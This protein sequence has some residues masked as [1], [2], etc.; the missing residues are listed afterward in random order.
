MPD[1]ECPLCDDESTFQVDTSISPHEY[2]CSACGSY[3]FDQMA[4]TDLKHLARLTPFEKRQLRFAIRR[5]T[6]QAGG[7]ML[8]PNVIGDVLQT[9]KP[10]AI[11]GILDT[12]RDEI[13]ARSI[14]SPFS[15]ITFDLSR[16]PLF[17]VDNRHALANV[18]I[19]L[20]SAGSI[21]INSQDEDSVTLFALPSALAP[22]P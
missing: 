4:G 17:W 12:V 16:F 11:E 22:A 10:P 2:D 5:E 18:L 14:E 8:N 3:S 19:V 7:L 21:H 20:E 6:E 13:V 9:C 1:P 15:S